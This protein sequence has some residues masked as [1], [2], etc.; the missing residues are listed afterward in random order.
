M[1]GNLANLNRALCLPADIGGHGKG[2]AWFALRCWG[3][4][5]GVTVCGSVDTL[6]P[7]GLQCSVITGNYAQET[8]QVN[9][10]TSLRDDFIFDSS[11]FWIT[12]CF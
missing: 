2:G 5:I 9:A 4:V 10:S 8:R 6:C 11:W 1:E 7:F 3:V 12:G